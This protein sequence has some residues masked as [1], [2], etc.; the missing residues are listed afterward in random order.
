M[1]NLGPL[2]NVLKDL[3]DLG[4]VIINALITT[5][6]RTAERLAVLPRVSM[7]SYLSMIVVGAHDE[8]GNP[9]WVQ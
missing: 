9:S 3:T 4:V 5:E 2:F 1:R 7:G 6:K 8:Q